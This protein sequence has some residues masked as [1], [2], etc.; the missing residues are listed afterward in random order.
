MPIAQKWLTPE[1]EAEGR[2]IYAQDVMYRAIKYIIGY[3]KGY[4]VEKEEDFSGNPLII[5][6]KVWYKEE[7]PPKEII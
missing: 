7:E 5:T 1:L 2:K 4:K 6:V 3:L